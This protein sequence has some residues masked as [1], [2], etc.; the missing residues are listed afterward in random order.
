MEG[1]QTTMREGGCA[2]QRERLEE[3]QG[4]RKVQGMVRKQEKAQ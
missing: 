2:R 3:R 4:S 1:F